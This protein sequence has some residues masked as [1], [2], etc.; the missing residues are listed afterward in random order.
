MQVGQNS[1]QLTVHFF[2]IGRILIAGSQ[3]RF[4]M[5]H[6]NL[7]VKSGQ[8]PDKRRGR[9]AVHQDQVGL[10]LGQHP[11]QSGQGPVGDIEQ[12]L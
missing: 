9:V 4:D 6:W 3:A 7:V 12:R 8:R 10:G 11:I 1:R 5:S 2:G